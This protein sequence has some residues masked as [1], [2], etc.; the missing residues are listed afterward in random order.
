[1]T[2]RNVL[3]SELILDLIPKINFSGTLP[4]T[5]LSRAV[6]IFGRCGTHE[7]SADIFTPLILRVLPFSNH[8]GVQLDSALDEPVMH[9]REIE[10]SHFQ[11]TF[12]NTRIRIEGTRCFPSCLCVINK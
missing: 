6:I 5:S 7:K 10:K 2:K 11:F 1:M 3:I 9:L 8:I 4:R 12:A